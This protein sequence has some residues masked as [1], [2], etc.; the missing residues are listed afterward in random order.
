MMTNA[1]FAMHV[2]LLVR[3]AAQWA[4]ELAYGMLSPD[5][6]SAEAEGVDRFIEEIEARLTNLRSIRDRNAHTET[7]TRGTE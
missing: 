2:S 1:V 7:A 5:Y 3:I 6:Y 4:H